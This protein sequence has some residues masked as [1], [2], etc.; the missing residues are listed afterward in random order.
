MG[1]V[2]VNVVNNTS[3]NAEKVGKKGLAKPMKRTIQEGK[4]IKAK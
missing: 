3:V 4:E 1:G 2:S